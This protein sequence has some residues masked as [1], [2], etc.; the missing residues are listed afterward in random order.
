MQNALAVQHVLDA[1]HRVRRAPAVNL[2]RVRRVDTERPR[3]P[4][5]PVVVER[6]GVEGAGA[7]RDHIRKR[8][9]FSPFQYPQI[10]FSSCGYAAE[11]A[12]AYNSRQ[13]GFRSDILNRLKHA[14][15]DAL[16]RLPL[17]VSGKHA[18]DVRIVR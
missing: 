3:L 5:L 9:F 13:T 15:R 18:V 16:R 8:E 6:R 10:R 17:A 2:V 12:L 11:N 1:F 14:C 7:V 4:D